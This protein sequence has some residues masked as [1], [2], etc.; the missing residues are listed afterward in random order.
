MK[1]FRKEIIS[2]VSGMAFAYT[3]QLFALLMCYIFDING[4]FI[5]KEMFIPAIGF[6]LSIMP[7]IAWIMFGM[8]KVSWFKNW[9][10]ITYHGLAFLIPFMFISG[11]T[12]FIA[13]SLWHEKMYWCGNVT[14]SI[15]LT[16]TLFRPLLNLGYSK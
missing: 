11:V 7:I 4:D 10:L 9:K 16:F 13:P 12:V 6:Q 5:T 3:Y 1:K 15:V 14:L 8:L 2:I